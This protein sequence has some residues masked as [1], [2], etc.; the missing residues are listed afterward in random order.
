MS[1]IAI[2][3][4]SALSPKASAAFRKYVSP[5]YDELTVLHNPDRR[6]SADDAAWLE[7]YRQ[8]VNQTHIVI[9]NGRCWLTR[10]MA[11]KKL[12]KFRST[13]SPTLKNH[14]ETETRMS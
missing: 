10:R 14:L 12:A 6:F 3:P 4:S 13:M 5:C 11:L 2:M 9:A 1:T 8:L 7:K